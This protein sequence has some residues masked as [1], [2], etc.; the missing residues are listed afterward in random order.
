MTN[1]WGELF[2]ILGDFDALRIKRNGFIHGTWKSVLIGDGILLNSQRKF[3]KEKG[4]T[5]RLSQSDLI[6]VEEIEELTNGIELLKTRLS[7][8]NDKLIFSDIHTLKK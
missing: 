2:K 4:S 5:F 6:K 3:K 7:R 1:A 8:I